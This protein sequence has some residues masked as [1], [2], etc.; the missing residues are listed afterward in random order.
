MPEEQA[1][2]TSLVI[3]PV[4]RGR[5]RLRNRQVR[6]ITRLARF[7]R[8]LSLHATI[9]RVLPNPCLEVHRLV[10]L[11]NRLLLR[12]S[13]LPPVPIVLHRVTRPRNLCLSL[14][15]EPPSFNP[16]SNHIANN[17]LT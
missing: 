1:L 4:P 13:D 7:G 2:A 10:T 14:D 3:L 6:L 5:P 9:L 12:H 17:Y 15:G 16:T 8:S 11:V